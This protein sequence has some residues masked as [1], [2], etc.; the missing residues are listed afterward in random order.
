MNGF[1][2][3]PA[4][5]RIRYLLNRR[6]LFRNFWHWRNWTCHNLIS[7]PC[8]DWGVWWQTFLVFNFVVL[9]GEY[10]TYKFAGLKARHFYCD[11]EWRTSFGGYRVEAFLEWK[12][13]W[14]TRD[15][16]QCLFLA[17]I[18]H[19][20]WIDWLESTLL[21]QSVLQ[22]LNYLVSKRLN[23]FLILFFYLFMYLLSN[24]VGWCQVARCAFKHHSYVESFNA[25]FFFICFLFLEN[26]EI[27][28]RDN[29]IFN[30]RCNYLR[31]LF[32]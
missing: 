12:I 32:F 10:V 9:T 5:L 2:L 18:E 1:D 14:T 28:S 17:N 8:G 4:M 6:L 7:V 23:V 26:D 24:K 16:G 29:H 20:Y 27:F 13:F 3:L 30:L 25:F 21:V 19:T 15:R 22:W 11:C 31:D